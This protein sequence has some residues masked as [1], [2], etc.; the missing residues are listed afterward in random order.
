MSQLDGADKDR[1]PLN[2]L[3]APGILFGVNR[4]EQVAIHSFQFVHTGFIE[5]GVN[6]FAEDSFLIFLAV[7]LNEGMDWDIKGIRHIEDRFKRRTLL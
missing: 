2:P 6:P 4:I 3:D 1:V 7:N 5:N